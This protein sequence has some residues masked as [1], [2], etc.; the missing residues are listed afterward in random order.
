MTRK[1][2]VRLAIAATALLVSAA[3]AA[4]ATSK[5]P[6][7][8][9][10]AAIRNGDHAVVKALLARGADTKQLNAE[11]ETPLMWAALYSDANMIQL[12]LK[13]GADPNAKS[14]A[15]TTALSWAVDDLNKV[16]L[17]VAAG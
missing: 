11:G 12:L 3:Q 5:Q 1:Q 10:F 13:R 14:Q 2:T 9:L 6:S 4:P 15:G 7:E 8:D 16:R 17:L